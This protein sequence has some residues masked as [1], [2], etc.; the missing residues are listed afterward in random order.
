MTEFVLVLRAIWR[1]WNE[2]E[3]LDF[4]GRFYRHDLISSGPGSPQPGGR[5]EVDRGARGGTHRGR[6]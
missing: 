3:P 4:H 6:P 5:V 2:G 1:C